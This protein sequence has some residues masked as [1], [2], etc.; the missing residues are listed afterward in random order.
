V[1][2]LFDITLGLVIHVQAGKCHDDADGLNGVNGLGKPYDSDAN[3]GDTFD[4]RSNRI[5]NRRG[6]GKD[7][8]SNDVLGKMNGSVEEEVVHDRVGGCSTFF[9]IASEVGVMFGGVIRSQEDWEIVVEP[10]WDHEDESHSRG[11]E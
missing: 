9:V 7:D 5:G 8:E 4:E 11:I 10:N 3:D 1:L 2:A 6:G